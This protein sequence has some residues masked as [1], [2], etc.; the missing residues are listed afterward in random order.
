MKQTYQYQQTQ[1]EAELVAMQRHASKCLSGAAVADGTDHDG[2]D[3]EHRDQLH[4]VAEDL[5]QVTTERQHISQQKY[6]AQS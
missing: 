4:D 3:Y 6:H 2:A 5:P 1:Q